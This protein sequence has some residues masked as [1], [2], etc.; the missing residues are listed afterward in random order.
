[1][2]SWI[3]LKNIERYLGLLAQTEN[4]SVCATLRELIAVEERKL[5]DAERGGRDEE[6]N[7]RR[8]PSPI[9][10]HELGSL[11]MD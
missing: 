4:P 3:A 7:R 8:D 1:M 11:R 2:G 5:L 6:A 9:L 10:F